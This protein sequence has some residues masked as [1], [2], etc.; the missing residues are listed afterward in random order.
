MYADDDDDDDDM[1]AME[2]IQIEKWQ[3]QT[4]GQHLL[5]KSQIMQSVEDDEDGGLNN[6]EEYDSGDEEDY[7]DL[8]MWTVPP[9]RGG[10][11]ESVGGDY[12]LGESQ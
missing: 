7:L 2:D 3:A 12:R 8:D 11:E 9:A 1:D 10:T 6:V 5:S 4:T